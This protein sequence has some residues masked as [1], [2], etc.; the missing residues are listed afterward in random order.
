MPLAIVLLLIV[1]LL[2]VIATFDWNRLKPIVNEHVSQAI[3]RPFVI[4]GDVHVTWTRRPGTTGI[5]RLIPWP[6]LRP[7]TSSW[8][9]QTGRSSRS[10]P[11]ST[12]FVSGWRPCH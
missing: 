2:M 10:S 4:Q 8:P 9:I 7:A 1:V 3:G 12:R 6:T 11:S 5:D